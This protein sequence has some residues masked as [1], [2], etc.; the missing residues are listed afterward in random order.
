[1]IRSTR[2]YVAGLVT[3]MFLLAPMALAQVTTGSVTGRVVD[4]S[5]GVVPG[6]NVVLIS[7]VHGN[8]IA[9]VKTNKE[10]EYVFPDITADT[11]TVEASAPA[12]KTRRE[13]GILVTGGDHVGRPDHNA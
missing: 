6:A 3:A 11:Y 7:E 9:P 1:M 8:R 10:G 4:S 12:F 5:G 13:T 2:N